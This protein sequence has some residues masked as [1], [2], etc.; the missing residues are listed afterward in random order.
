[1]AQIGGGL[2][3]ADKRNSDRRGA[4]DSSPFHPQE[5]EQPLPP[6]AGQPLVHRHRLDPAVGQEPVERRDVLSDG[7]HLP[8]VVS[9]LTSEHFENFP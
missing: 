2:V 3:H 5:K 9:Q 7:H 8:L 1:M 4:V 6:K